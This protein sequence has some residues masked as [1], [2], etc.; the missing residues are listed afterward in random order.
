MA[1]RALRSR[2]PR[3]RT[4][5]LLPAVLLAVVTPSVTA[6]GELAAA[7]SANAPP[8]VDIGA[9]RSVTIP[10]AGTPSEF[11]EVGMDM[12][13]SNVPERQALLA[14]VVD[15]VVP[16]AVARGAELIVDGVG[17]QGYNGGSP[18]LSVNTAA[19]V[20]D[21]NMTLQE[22]E[23]ATARAVVGA[24]ERAQGADP[25]PGSDIIGWLR[26]VEQTHRNH[27]A[28]D[29]LAVYVGDGAQNT[30]DCGVLLMPLETPAQ[31]PTIVRSCTA[32]DPLDLRGVHVQLLG[33]GLAVG[34]S[35]VSE[36]EALGLQHFLIDL[37]H[38]AGAAS[39]DVALSPVPGTGT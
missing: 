18:L 12:S 37:V 9:H 10:P 22:S 30:P 3:H 1:H 28:A 19:P 6:C 33:V 35:G 39:V 25:A 7:R 23:V 24:I 38:D 11:V 2:A 5:L 17:A 36:P 26:R 8:S 13:A 20:A 31:I 15:T 16:E 34:E 14:D 27:P 21:G 4:R 32:A 29:F